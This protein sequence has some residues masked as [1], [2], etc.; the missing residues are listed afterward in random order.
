MASRL[1][2]VLPLDSVHQDHPS[3][4]PFRDLLDVLVMG[5]TATKSVSRVYADVNAKLGP[6]WHEY[7]EIAC[8]RSM[9]ALVHLF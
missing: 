7:G 9:V 1:P 5:R 8:G 2:P 4:T 3:S 6:S